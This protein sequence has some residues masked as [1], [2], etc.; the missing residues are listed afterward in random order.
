MLAK[1]VKLGLPVVAVVAMAAPAAGQ[2]CH[3]CEEFSVFE[4]D[5]Y[6]CGWH[7]SATFAECEPEEAGL[8]NCPIDR[9][10]PPFLSTAER[11]AVDRSIE[12]LDGAAEITVNLA[13]A[14]LTEA[15]AAAHFDHATETL[16][17]TDCRGEA[18]SQRRLP[19]SVA[20]SLRERLDAGVEA[21]SSGP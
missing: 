20:A 1:A 11:V 21:T 12:L 3:T 7:V 15:P 9:C 14:V 18:I 8:G 5:W 4:E 19:P 16:T 2:A 13:L 10:Y 17:V 6:E